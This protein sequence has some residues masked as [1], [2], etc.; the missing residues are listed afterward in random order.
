VVI[1]API[2]PGE[3]YTRAAE[4]TRENQPFGDPEQA[5]RAINVPVILNVFWANS[6]LHCPGAL[7]GPNPSS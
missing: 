3:R 5:Q 2:M 1:A 4:M 6:Q 7:P